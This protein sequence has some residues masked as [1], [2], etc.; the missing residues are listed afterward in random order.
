MIRSEGVVI[1]DYGVG[2]TSFLYSILKKEIPK[3]HIPTILESYC[4]EVN[5]KEDVRVELVLHDTPGSQEYIQF[6][7]MS[8]MK[9]DFVLLCFS[10]VMPASYK[11]I[12]NFVSNH[13]QTHTIII[14][15]HIYR[16]S[17]IQYSQY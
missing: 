11:S 3:R 12:S 9:K 2:K 1:G 10:L 5:V 14:L 13:S 16:Y 7:Q 8:L 6:A 4:M 17:I 15:L